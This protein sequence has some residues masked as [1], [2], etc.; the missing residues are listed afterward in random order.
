MPTYN[1]GTASDGV[2]I[3]SDVMNASWSAGGAYANSYEAKISSAQGSYLSS[4][5]TISAPTAV[6][7]PTIT[8]PAVEI[9]ST[10]NGT[11]WETIFDSKY[12]ELAAWLDSKFTTFRTNFFPDENAAYTAAE[13]AL[14]AMLANPASYLPAAVQAQFFGDDQARIL[15][16]KTR[17]QDA[18]VAQF[19]ARR[20]PL[21]PDVAASAALQIEQKAQDELAESSRK[22]AMMS[23]DQFRFVVEKTLGLRQMAMGAAIDYIKALASGPDMASKLVGVGYDA[24]SKLISSA[25]SFYNARTQA[26][27]TIAK[28]QQFNNSTALEVSVKNQASELALIE[29][30]LK[31]LVAEAG[32]I[33]Q[34]ATSLFNNLH[35]SVSA[36]DSF[37]RS[38]GYSYSNDT[39]NT[40]TGMT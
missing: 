17:A 13:D 1:F 16:D 31:A 20:F 34:M 23:V 36:S 25:A 18:V 3:L 38:V 2:N 37:S 35:A 39:A 6:S 14:Q 19:A 11:D 33:A 27:E 26:A 4:A 28:I 22:I 40:P 7:V 29:D 8:E 5:P 21:P 12:L 10:Q 9:P 32:G 30:K 15:G 24:Q